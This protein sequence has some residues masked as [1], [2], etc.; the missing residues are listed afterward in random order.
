[1]DKLQFNFKTRSFN[2]NNALLLAKA[3]KAVYE[4]GDSA[5]SR[6]RSA[7]NF[8]QFRY[9]EQH[10]TQCFAAA[11]EQSVILA[12]RGTSSIE[13]WMTNVKIQKVPGPLGDTRVHKGFYKALDC[14]WDQTADTV[15]EFQ[16]D[17]KKQLWITGHSLGGAL[18]M[19]AAARFLE[20]DR[21]VKAL[22]TLGQPRVGDAN[23]SDVFEVWFNDFYRLVNN[24]DIV[25][26][27]PFAGYRHAGQEIYFDNDGKLH[28]DPGWLKKH[29][30]HVL[31]VEI[32][33]LEKFRA[34]RQQYPNSVQDHGTDRYIRNIRNA[35]VRE[36]GVTTFKDYL[37]AM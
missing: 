22:Y 5:C 7:W 31:S 23:F 25:T 37:N 15:D 36:R 27:V 11:D 12:F 9:I 28:K 1:M 29:S 34:M 20:R 26:R 32:R 10:D 13:D 17:R 18:A 19:L 16:A 30:D 2:L 21:P 6:M 3:S 8:Q 35:L 14:V 33:S 24:E 4:S